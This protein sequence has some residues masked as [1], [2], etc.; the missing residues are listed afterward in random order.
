MN[1]QAY[2]ASLAARARL[3]ADNVQADIRNAASRQEHMRL[4]RLAIEAANLAS[5]LERLTGETAS[6]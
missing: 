1:E 4:S 3:H 2:L 5:A 6:E